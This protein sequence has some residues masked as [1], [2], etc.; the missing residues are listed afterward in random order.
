MA[1]SLF[2]RGVPSLPGSSVIGP[3]EGHEREQC[4]ASSFTFAFCKAQDLG[5]N[6]V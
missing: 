5:A 1:S 2:R 4:A 3:G 6:V